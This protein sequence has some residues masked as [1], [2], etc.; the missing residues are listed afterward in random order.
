MVWLFVLIPLSFMAGVVIVGSIKES[1]FSQGYLKGESYDTHRA[2][3]HNSFSRGQS[4]SYKW[5]T[6]GN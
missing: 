6:G 4:N 5:Y 1:F 2:E 3:G